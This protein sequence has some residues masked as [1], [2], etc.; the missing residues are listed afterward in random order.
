MG[1]FLTDI[2]INVY[3]SLGYNYQLF[4]RIMQLYNC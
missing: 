4:D 1:S 2:V 3:Y